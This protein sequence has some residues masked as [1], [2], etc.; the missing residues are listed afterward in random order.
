[1]PAATAAPTAA[2]HTI[3]EA[4]PELSGP[5]AT[6]RDAM[7]ADWVVAAREAGLAAPETAMG[8]YMET[9]QALVAE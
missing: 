1:N 8:F 3:T 5:V 9:Y 6:S 4:S 7:V 2:G